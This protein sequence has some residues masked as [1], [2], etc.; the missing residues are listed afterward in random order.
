M[1]PDHVN[2]LGVWLDGASVG[3][4][5][6]HR[7]G[8][9]YFAYTPEWLKSGFALSP[10]GGFQ[11]GDR[12]LPTSAFATA[13]RE[14]DGLHGVFNDALPDGW[15]LKLMDRA[16]G[17]N[18]GWARHEITPLDRLAYMGTRAMGA[19]EFRPPLDQ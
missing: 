1:K 9:I 12:S 11:N 18:P 16:L 4:L 6:R 19:L 2:Q 17:S 14:F 5:A 15:G 7:T 13:S 10:L 8:T 3:T